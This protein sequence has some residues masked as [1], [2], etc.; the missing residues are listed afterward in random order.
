MEKER[1]GEGERNGKEMKERGRRKGGKGRERKGKKGKKRKR[2]KYF[3]ESGRRDK[4]ISSFF[5]SLLNN[6]RALEAKFLREG[7]IIGKEGKSSI[8]DLLER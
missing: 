6:A 7:I 3:N 1:K 2:K 5:E 4:A 8:G